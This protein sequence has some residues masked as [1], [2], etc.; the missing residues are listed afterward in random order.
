VLTAINQNPAAEYSDLAD[1]LGVSLH[2]FKKHLSLALS[3][4]QTPN[5][6]LAGIKH[7]ERLGLL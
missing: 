4:L 5:N 7:A 3:R 1:D 6:K 2:T